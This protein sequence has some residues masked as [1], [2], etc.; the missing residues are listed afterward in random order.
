MGGLTSG[1]GN[2]LSLLEAVGVPNCLVETVGVGQAEMAVRDFCD[3][4][5][6]LVAP[7]AGDDLQAMKR[8]ITEVVKLIIVNKVDNPDDPA[9]QLAA[10][11]Y[12]QSGR[13]VMTVSSHTG[14]GIPEAWE[15]IKQLTG[16][17]GERRRMQERKQLEDMTLKLLESKFRD[18]L[19]GRKVGNASYG[20]ARRLIADFISHMRG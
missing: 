9:G 10:A 15:R 7:G 16:N 18:F 20:E 6:L 5:V 13:P 11:H 17:L 12:R 3:V 8:G 19:K 1:T 14:R 4:T 2:V